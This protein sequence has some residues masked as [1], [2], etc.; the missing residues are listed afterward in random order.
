VSVKNSE[1]LATHN[2]ADGSVDLELIKQFLKR[3]R[4]VR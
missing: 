4:P 2:R 1:A 3:V